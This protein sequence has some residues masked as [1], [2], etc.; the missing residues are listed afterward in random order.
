MS[1][2]SF[3]NNAKALV[4]KTVDNITTQKN[5]ALQTVNY[6]ANNA[7]NN[8]TTVKNEALQTV[9]FHV[10]NV[11]TKKNNAIQNVVNT[12]KGNQAIP[13]NNSGV[14]DTEIPLIDTSIEFTTPGM[15]N[16]TTSGLQGKLS[17]EQKAKLISR[18]ELFKAF[19]KANKWWFIGGGTALASLILWLIF[20]KKKTLKKKV[21]K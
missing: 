14:A 6:H 18:W 15:G 1:L 7:L 12:I 8:V 9:K 10:D 17:D 21:R 11:T 4:T 3:V 19:V 5:E 2:K 20:R 16:T 13:D